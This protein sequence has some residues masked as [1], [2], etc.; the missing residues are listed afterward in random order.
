MIEA[1][2]IGVVKIVLIIL[3]AFMLLRFLGQ[4]MNAKRNINEEKQFVNKQ[5]DYNSLKEE[6]ERNKGKINV[7]DKKKSASDYKE[8]SDYEE[9]Q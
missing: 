3:G 7:S 1:S 2:F 6:I 9:I 5:N 4:L 8:Y